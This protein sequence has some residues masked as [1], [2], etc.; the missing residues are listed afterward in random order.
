MCVYC[1]LRPADHL[2][3]IVPCSRGG[4]GALVNLA[5]ACRPCGQSKGDLTVVE[6]MAVRA[7]E[8]AAGR[9]PAGSS[10]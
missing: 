6:W 3:H 9:D 8:T 10:V 1:T 7:A 4:S 2:D 5:P